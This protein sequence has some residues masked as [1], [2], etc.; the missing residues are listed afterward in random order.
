[1][2]VRR[3]PR[4]PGDDD[5]PP[6]RAAGGFPV[7]R[8]LRFG[9]PIGALPSPRRR[10]RSAELPRQNR[11]AALRPVRLT[12]MPS[13]SRLG[14]GSFREDVGRLIV[15]ARERRTRPSGKEIFMRVHPQ[16]GPQDGREP[17][18]SAQPCAQNSWTTIAS[19]VAGTGSTPVGRTAAC[20]VAAPPRPGPAGTVRGNRA[21]PL[22][23]H[24]EFS[25][26]ACGPV[27]KTT[28]RLTVEPGR[29]TSTSPVSGLVR[30][31]KSASTQAQPP[32][33]VRSRMVRRNRPNPRRTASSR[34]GITTAA[35]SGCPSAAAVRPT[36]SPGSM[37]V[38]S[39]Y[40][41]LTY[42]DRRRPSTGRRC[43]GSG[44]RPTPG[45]AGTGGGR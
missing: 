44:R 27:T 29:S 3:R 18:L 5:G 14:T 6:R 37:P 40:A 23:R 11:R 20:V 25:A 17:G 19:E 26:A 16:V 12:S 32:A 45:R 28:V 36:T 31:E 33:A 13:P 22:H 39:R 35:S 38:T 2:T 10:A 4:L 41:S 24:R 43:L 7:A 21:D 42:V 15:G 1:M 9:R 30:T 34:M 8:A